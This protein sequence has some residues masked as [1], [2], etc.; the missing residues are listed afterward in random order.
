MSLESK[1]CAVGKKTSHREGDVEDTRPLPS[2]LASATP[3]TVSSQDPQDFSQRA[4]GQQA[5][6]GCS[7]MWWGR[8][9]GPQGCGFHQLPEDP[10]QR[11]AIPRWRLLRAG[12]T[13]CPTTASFPRRRSEVGGSPQTPAPLERKWCLRGTGCGRHGQSAL[14]EVRS[15][16]GVVPRAIGGKTAQS[17][18][19]K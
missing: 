7:L 2:R 15:F 10:G 12:R 17:T 6:D 19:N 16:L 5:C 14:A 3:S 11:G 1:S 9:A 13:P 8:S 4:S 18:A